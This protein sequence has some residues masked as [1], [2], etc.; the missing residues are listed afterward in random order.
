MRHQLG[1]Y[2]HL[3]HS[4]YSLPWDV[5]FVMGTVPAIMLMAMCISA[6]QRRE[7]KELSIY[8]QAHGLSGVTM[9][10]DRCRI[11]LPMGNVG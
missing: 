5:D 8:V 4:Q 3:G 1:S 7:A 11:M 6:G 9:I 10:T 2:Q